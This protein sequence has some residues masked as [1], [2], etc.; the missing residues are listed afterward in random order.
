MPNT[1]ALILFT[2]L[3]IVCAGPS[4][5]NDFVGVIDIIIENKLVERVNAWIDYDG[6]KT[7]FDFVRDEDNE[8]IYRFNFYD[9]HLTYD[10]E[11]YSKNCTS[12]PLM[13]SLAPVFA[14]TANSTRNPWPCYANVQQGKIGVEW[15]L[16][17]N[18]NTYILCVDDLDSDRPWWLHK[19]TPQG[20]EYLRFQE[21]IPGVPPL[22][23]FDLPSFCS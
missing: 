23:A 4:I 6:Q 3:S 9:T 7:R 22:H 16:E 1:K 13:E 17:R 11:I 5:S 18:G 10:A 14:W 20:N 2:L 15:A 12:S 21:F 8:L 19:V